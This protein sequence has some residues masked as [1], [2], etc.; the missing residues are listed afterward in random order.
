MEKSTKLNPVQLHLIQLFSINMSNNELSEIKNL[1]VDY[2]NKRVSIESD[3]IWKEKAYTN[4]YMDEILNT[5][6]QR[7]KK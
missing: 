6:I 1:L 3:R 2:Y 5:H 7:N 4:M